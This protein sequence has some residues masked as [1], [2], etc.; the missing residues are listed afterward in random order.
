MFEEINNMATQTKA[1]ALQ[2]KQDM[3]D[4]IEPTF[5]IDGLHA[6]F[7]LLLFSSLGLVVITFT[8]LFPENLSVIWYIYHIGYI[9]LTTGLILLNLG[10]RN[11]DDQILPAL[12]L[13]EMILFFPIQVSPESTLVVI[14]CCLVVGI[15]VVISITQT[16]RYCLARGVGTGFGRHY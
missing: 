8:M 1:I 7:G 15:I 3:A 16:W 6:R 13:V 2:A 9:I 11:K 5:Y 14:A 12:T 10:N 4:L